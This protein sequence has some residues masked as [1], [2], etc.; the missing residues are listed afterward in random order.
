MKLINGTTAAR[1]SIIE[2]SIH[3][4]NERIHVFS[5]RPSSGVH[6][7]WME[8]VF[9]IYTFP[10]TP[11]IHIVSIITIFFLSTRC[12]ST[13]IHTLFK[14]TYL[15]MGRN[16]E[17]GDGIESTLPNQTENQERKKQI[18]CNNIETRLMC[19]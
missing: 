17:R 3:A 11:M 1:A 5:W 19:R 7:R 16:V 14:H 2:K 9:D 13:C 15:R 18:E 12:Y 8:V 6:C 10:S 4:A